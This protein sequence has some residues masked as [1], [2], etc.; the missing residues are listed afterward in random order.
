MTRKTWATDEQ[1]AFL[2]GYRAS[3]KQAQQ[4]KTTGAFL[5]QL[6]NDWFAKY[7]LHAP[8]AREVAEATEEVDTEN[9][10]VELSADDRARK[11]V[12]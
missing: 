6:K 12:S 11:I 2:M 1:V 3:F 4:L 8:D 5:S 7:P 9:A 10:G